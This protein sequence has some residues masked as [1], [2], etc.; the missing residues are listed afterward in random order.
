MHRL[1]IGLVTESLG[2]ALNAFHECSTGPMCWIAGFPEG[3]D[4]DPDIACKSFL[5]GYLFA[6]G[7]IGL[8]LSVFL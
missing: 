5:S 6:G 4:G 1:S 8:F 3:C 7:P 2:V